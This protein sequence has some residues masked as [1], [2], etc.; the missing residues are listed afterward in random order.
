MEDRAAI[1]PAGEWGAPDKDMAC[2]GVYDGHGGR[3]MM[4]NAESVRINISK[5]LFSFI[6]VARLLIF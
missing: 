1:Y 6:Q 5:R 4:D 3:F 2:F